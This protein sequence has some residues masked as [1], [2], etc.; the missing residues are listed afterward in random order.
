MSFAREIMDILDGDKGSSDQEGVTE[1]MQEPVDEALGLLKSHTNLTSL[2]QRK[3]DAVSAAFG[4]AQQEASRVGRKTGED[5]KQ[6]VEIFMGSPVAALRE[7]SAVIDKSV[8]HMEGVSRRQRYRASGVTGFGGSWT[9]LGEARDPMGGSSQ[10]QNYGDYVPAMGKINPGDAVNLG[11]RVFRV[12]GKSGNSAL[13]QPDQLRKQAARYVPAR[14]YPTPASPTPSGI[15]TPQ[16]VRM[17]APQGN[18]SNPSG[19]TSLVGTSVL[20]YN[21]HTGQFAFCTGKMPGDYEMA[22]TIQIVGH[23]PTMPS[24]VGEGIT[25]ENLELMLSEAEGNDIIEKLRSIAESEEEALVNDVLVDP[26]TAEAAV[27]MYE[28]LSDENQER[29]EGMDIHEALRVTYNV[30]GKVHGGGNEDELDEARGPLTNPALSGL[31]GFMA[32]FGGGSVKKPKMKEVGA[33]A[34]RFLT[35]GEYGEDGQSVEDAVKMWANRL[36]Q[37]LPKMNKEWD[38]RGWASFKYETHLGPRFSGAKAK[39]DVLELIPRKR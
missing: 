32:S 3:L 15:N 25:V 14:G 34:F 2:L 22:D 30:M 7:L 18:L 13:V 38:R 8:Q 17:R 31:R 28:G 27:R 1:E 37:A 29:L 6:V 21:P 5:R 24:I 36:N 35:P 11:G 9:A 20:R 12:I 23:D 4:V 16:D 33:N 19:R 39:G 10:L 26:F